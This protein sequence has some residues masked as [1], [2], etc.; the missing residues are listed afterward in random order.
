MGSSIAVVSGA[1]GTLGT[2]VTRAL[3]DRGLSVVAVS[4]SG[5][6]PCPGI[7]AAVSADL[8]FDDSVPVVREIGRAHV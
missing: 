7:A 3:V 1:T 5:E 6:E 8:G 4:R 2:L